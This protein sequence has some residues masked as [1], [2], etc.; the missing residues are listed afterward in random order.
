MRCA[1]LTTHAWHI[2]VSGLIWQLLR[3]FPSVRW[4]CHDSRVSLLISEQQLCQLGV[5]TTVCIAVLL[6]ALLLL[7]AWCCVRHMRD[8]RHSMSYG[9][10]LSPD[11]EAGATSKS[12]LCRRSGDAPLALDL[13]RC[14]PFVPPST[15]MYITVYP[16][17]AQAAVHLHA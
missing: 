2:C 13:S 5:F 7:L 4:K 16:M 15:C 12:A 6:S 10:D 17:T 14:A 11:S 1:R 8:R 9:D 3:C